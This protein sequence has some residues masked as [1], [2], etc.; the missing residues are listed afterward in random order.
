MDWMKPASKTDQGS[1]LPHAHKF[2]LVTA[3]PS[4]EE[5][6]VVAKYLCTGCTASKRRTVTLEQFQAEALETTPDWRGS[7]SVYGEDDVRRAFEE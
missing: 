2:Q 6:K 4:A 3:D 1:G 7:K 5:G